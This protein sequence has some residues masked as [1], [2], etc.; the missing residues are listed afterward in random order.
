MD[1]LTR[2]SIAECPSRALADAGGWIV[3]GLSLRPGM[4]NQAEHGAGGGQGKRVGDE[5]RII[6]YSCKYSQ[7]RLEQ[8]SVS[9]SWVQRWENARCGRGQSWARAVL[10]C[11]AGYIGHELPKPY[12]ESARLRSQSARLLQIYRAQADGASFMWFHRISIADTARDSPRVCAS[13]TR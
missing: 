10:E 8:L 2:S 12:P 3:A 9:E 4:E 5:R 13:R 11:R 6:F 1:V 7:M